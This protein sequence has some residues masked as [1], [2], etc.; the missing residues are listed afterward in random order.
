MATITLSKNRQDIGINQCEIHATLSGFSIP[1]DTKTEKYSANGEGYKVEINDLNYNN[2]TEEYNIITIKGLNS[3]S[4]YEIKITYQINYTI[5][6]YKWQG[7]GEVGSYVPTGETGSGS[8]SASAQIDVYTRPS[9]F[10]SWDNLKSGNIIESKTE[11]VSAKDVNDFITK[12]SQYHSW[13]AQSNWYNS[14]NSTYNHSNNKKGW[15]INENGDWIYADWYNHLVKHINEYFIKE[16][17]TVTGGANGTLI[18][19]KHFTDLADIINS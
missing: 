14:Y 9:N 4:S 3:G 10:T 5:T 17:P 8:I 13:Y 6:Y 15:R 19:A 2:W 16:L 18:T 12:L 11:G 7:E 1:L